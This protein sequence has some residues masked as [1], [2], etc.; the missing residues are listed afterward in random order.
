VTSADAVQVLN[1]LSP[2]AT[3][4]SNANDHNRDK[5]VTT[6]DALT[7]LNNLAIGP[8]ALWK[9]DL[10]PGGSLFSAPKGQ[11]RVSPL[12]LSPGWLS[13]RRQAAF[14]SAS[15]ARVCFLSFC[16]LGTTRAP[17]K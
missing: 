5:F 8:D 9:L 12:A 10:G 3:T 16:E 1:N 4:I 6:S 13:V 15:I 2:F 11:G 17:S 14:N 7:T